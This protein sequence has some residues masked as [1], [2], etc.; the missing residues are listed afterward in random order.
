[1][2]LGQLELRRGDY[3]AARAALLDALAIYDRTGPLAS[4]LAV[5]REL[6]AA[7]AAAG[8]LQGALDGLRRTERLADSLKAPPGARAGIALARADLAVQLNTLGEA[9]RLYVRAAYLY[10]QG[11]DPSGEAEAQE[12]RGLLF[13][14]RDDQARARQLLERSEE[15][16][17]G[18][19]GRSR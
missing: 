11:G 6:A 14:L 5:R 10:H 1:H 8:E 13:L 17:V 4:A 15:R 19:E 7:L 18:K 16:R 9:E 12:G 3:R 2:G